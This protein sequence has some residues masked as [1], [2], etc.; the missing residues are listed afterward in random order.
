[1]GYKLYYEK[2]QDIRFTINPYDK[3]VGNEVIIRKKFTLAYYVDGNK[4]YHVETKVV[5]KILETPKRNL[6]GLNHTKRK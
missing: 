4:L 6:W 3:C 2:L 1:M 5:D